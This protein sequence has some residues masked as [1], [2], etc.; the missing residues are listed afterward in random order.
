MTEIIEDSPFHRGEQI[1]QARAGVRERMERFGRQVIHDHLPE[2]H[3][4]FY[5]QLPF[6]LV[7][8]A[9]KEGWPWASILFNQPGFISTGDARKMQISASPVAGD[10]LENALHKGT[11][12]GLLGIELSTRRRNRVAA[13]ITGV[14]NDDIELQVDQAF[15]NCPQYIQGRELLTVDPQAMPAPVVEPISDLSDE[16]RR[17]IE[18]SDTFFVASY[19][20]NDSGQSS[21]G[22]DVSHRGGKPGFIRIDGNTL[23]IPDYRGNNHFNT[24]GNF[25]ETPKAGLLFVDFEHGHLLTLTGRVEVLWDATET[26]DFAGAERLWKL[27]LDHGFYQKNVLPLRWRLDLSA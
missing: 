6:V 11:H 26:K 18:N 4:A 14:S 3:R 5:R 21:D 7:G 20:H 15:G 13:Q 12:L 9:D 22:A 10:P 23:I 2:Q 27:H 25:H 16:T 1:L 19:K 8:H 17:L 24:L